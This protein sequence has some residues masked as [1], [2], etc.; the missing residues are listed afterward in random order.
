MRAYLESVRGSRL[1]LHSHKNLKSRKLLG[2]LAL[3]IA[4]FLAT[5][6]SAGETGPN[7][8]IVVKPDTPEFTINL[9]SNR[10]TG[11]SWYLESISSDL[12]EAKRH[13][14]E[15]PPA[16]RVGAPGRETWTFEAKQKAFLVPRISTI[17]FRY[18]RPWEPKSGQKEQFTV[19]TNPKM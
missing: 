19:I 3:A 1:I 10:T 17:V 13:A 5:P 9:E 16:D 11:F 4:L 14:Y 2:Y 7:K 15:A 12:I 8:P 18:Q 6:T